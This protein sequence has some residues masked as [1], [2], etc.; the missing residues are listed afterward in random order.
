M[1]KLWSRKRRHE[2]QQQGR[3]LAIVRACVRACSKQWL[4][5]DANNCRL[6]V[7]REGT[8]TDRFPKNKPSSR[9]QPQHTTAEN[10]MVEALSFCRS[11]NNNRGRGH[12]MCC[13]DIRPRSL[14]STSSWGWSLPLAA[15]G[16]DRMVC[17]SPL[18]SFLPYDEYQINTCKSADVFVVD[19]MKTMVAILHRGLLVLVVDSFNIADDREEITRG[20]RILSVQ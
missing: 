18:A 13:G 16:W 7:Q 20:G 10:P 11:K 12:G 4:L 3:M 5:Y 9:K 1:Q 8:G 6:A 15:M 2:L 17:M 19:E 14:A